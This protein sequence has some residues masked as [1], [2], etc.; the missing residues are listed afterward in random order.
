MEKLFF[1]FVIPAHNEEKYIVNTL[2]HLQRLEYPAD[3]YEVL[4]IENG[5]TDR[6]LELAKQFERAGCNVFQSGKGASKARNVGIDHVSPKSDWII[7]LD[8]DTVI[9]KDFL[10]ELNSRLSGKNA[11]S[12]GTTSLRPLPARPYANF[13]YGMHNFGHMLTK[14]SFAIVIARRDLFPQLRFDE[15]LSSGEDLDLIRNAQ[16]HGRFFYL[17]TKSVATSTRRFDKVGWLRLTLQ[18][19]F[20]AILPKRMQEEIDYG[21]VR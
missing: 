12:V 8:A 9:E 3:H 14:T 11:L 15:R 13:W 16:K 20:G 10:N 4:V 5:S 17:R 21:V 19:T 6:T 18:W 1:S 2:E 7:F